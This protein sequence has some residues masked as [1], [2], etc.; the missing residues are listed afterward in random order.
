MVS[1][2]NTPNQSSSL[3]GIA[4]NAM[5]ILLKM[6]AGSTDFRTQSWCR[7]AFQFHRNMINQLKVRHPIHNAYHIHPVSN[8]TFYP[9]ITNCVC[10]W[11]P[12]WHLNSPIEQC[13]ILAQ[14]RQQDIK[15]RPS[16]LRVYTKKEVRKKMGNEVTDNWLRQF[17]EAL[18]GEAEELGLKRHGKPDEV[19]DW[20]L[21]RDPEFSA[22]AV[23]ML[24]AS[25]M[26]E[27]RGKSW[28]G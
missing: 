2:D 28:Q 22:H 23:G 15:F 11:T 21:Y 7:I 5:N 4:F 16:L 26:N 24:I 19:K 13:I 20:N 6:L 18:R 17:F 1:L 9:T 3:L 8:G 14:K 10:D 27:E 25:A 12:S